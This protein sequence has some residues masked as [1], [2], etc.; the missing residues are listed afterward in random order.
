MIDTVIKVDT[1]Y[2]L[3]KN[4]GVLTVFN[5]NDEDTLIDP[6]IEETQNQEAIFTFQV[7]SSSEKWTSTYNP[8]NLYLVDGKMF[9]AS[10][11]DSI[12]TVLDEEGK[13][14]ITVVAYERQK[15]L[16]REYV[17]VYN[18][19]TGFEEVDDMGEPV[20]GGK[21]YI[22]EF[23]VIVLSGGDKELLNGGHL[24]PTE[25][26]K[27]TS[28]YALDAVL[29]GT[30]WK[31]GICDVEG[32]F[33]L[34]TDQMSIYE[35]I[36][37]IQEIWG[38]IIVVDSLNKVIH[39]RDETKYL[40]Y[41]GYEV[42][43]EKNLQTYEYIGDNKIIT[44]LCPLG[45]GS[46]NIK[47]VN[48]DSIW[49]TN[50]SYTDTVY[51]SIENNDDI[52]DAEQLKRWGERKL[53]ELCKPRKELTVTFPLLKHVEGFEL[54]EIHLNDIV[55]VTN[56]NLEE[57]KV[58][59]LR[60]I[61]FTHKI[62]S[63]EDAEITLGD[64]TLESTDIFK[65]NIQATNS[66]NNGT[67]NTSQII[68]YYK[69][70][71]SLKEIL[72]QVDQTIISTKSEL[73]KTDDTIKASVEQ[74]E[75]NIDN[76]NNDI[77]SQSRT[78]AELLVSVG[79]ITSKVETVADLTET[80]T[81]TQGRVVLDKAVEGY[82]LGLSI[83]GY[84]GSFKA[85]YLDDD[86]ILSDDLYLLD[87]S[88]VLNVYTK[89]KCPTTEPYYE[90]GYIDEN[91][92]E[93][94]N[95]QI[96]SIV[97]KHYLA[98]TIHN[99]AIIKET[100]NDQTL[101][102]LNIKPNS[103]YLI[104]LNVS[105]LSEK[106]LFT[107]G[108]YSNNW[109]DLIQEE[110]FQ[111]FAV[112]A[113]DTNAY[114]DNGWKYDT[115]KISYEITTTENDEQLIIYKSNSIDINNI[116]IK[117][118]TNENYLKTKNPFAVVPNSEM[119][120]SLDNSNY[121]FVDIYFYDEYKNYINSWN[122]LN[123]TSTV[124]NITEKQIDIPENV[125]FI[126]YVITKALKG[127]PV[128]GLS[129]L[130]NFSNTLNTF[131]EDKP[132][133][134]V[135]GLVKPE[136]EQE[137]D[138][139]LIEEYTPIITPDLISEIRPQL[140]YGDLKT[141]FINY[142]TQRWEFQ[143][144]EELRAVEGEEYLD[145][146]SPDVEAGYELG[147][148]S[149]TTGNKT[150]AEN[151]LRILDLL[152]IKDNKSLKFIIED[153]IFKFNNIFF[154]N[155]FKEYIGNWNTLN[156]TDSID[157][158]T[159]KTINLPEGTRYITYSIKKSDNTDISSDNILDLSLK[160]NE[161]TK[162]YDEFTIVDKVAMLIRRI[163]VDDEGNNYVMT[164]PEYISYGEIEIPIV[165]GQ[166]ILE[167]I[168]YK[169]TIVAEFA[170]QNRYTDLFA[171]KVEVSTVIQQTDDK[172]LLS[173]SK[174]VSKDKLIEEFN[175][176]IAI[177]PEKILIE[178]NKIA[179]KSSYFEL[180]D[181]GEITATKGNIAGFRMWTDYNDEGIKR[182]WLTKDFIH[183]GTTYRSGILIMDSAGYDSDFIF[184]GMPVGDNGSFNTGNANFRVFHNGNIG[185]QSKDGTFYTIYE[186]GNYSM[187]YYD[188][189]IERFLPNKNKWT[190]EGIRI[191]WWSCKCSLFMVI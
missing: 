75:T 49:L 118:I 172:I 66:V 169:P 99:T 48:D 57:D 26:K 176:Q 152:D 191:C 103:K 72:R 156:S 174:Q 44:Q 163:A 28:G 145:D 144:D 24:V 34:E 92:L 166:N 70:G 187:R 80:I 178:G 164:N 124:F 183:N 10:F 17:Q 89:N 4:E 128:S 47:S 151:R 3:N 6:Q 167:V 116:T 33:D 84:N 35:N 38:G 46:L 161:K 111:E 97:T 143:L 27:G 15:L 18:S 125:Y 87:T 159:E 98:A 177:T 146:I 108:S 113:Y 142:N 11:S 130:S 16:E 52:Y 1:V 160:I 5:K 153:E 64:I 100:T 83:H 51:K 93:N 96:Q 76:L 190:V 37:K 67:L 182:S 81:N 88:I 12:D 171:T 54:E 59:Q 114:Y 9:S 25:H 32:T 136:G 133:D 21:I 101:Y 154:Y 56:Y 137:N 82:L 184:A 179:I 43:E 78:L 157:G 86:T 65:K 23:M 150:E 149:E 155:A 71:Q 186:N 19:T 141:E 74:I 115:T 58:A 45:E 148:Y 105:S 138:D 90:Q 63:D 139:E 158:V 62:W 129:L 61:A 107:V 168:Y 53:Q 94:L 117:D 181:D 91:T 22:D 14:I 119:Y 30:G 69:N 36:A 31:T 39:H 122:T 7:P 134:L 40:P 126:S 162:T 121:R 180:T 188:D 147:N 123:P 102:Y 77:V 95:N 29:Y 13:E 132:S 50:F 185:I 73:S 2:V 170:V 189:R 42:K 104:N 106:A 165:Q 79:E 68:D 120:F 131:V 85:T 8:E 110:D 55:D 109:L 127:I 175:S 140:E 60:V 173:A 112:N 20:E 41:S 135:G